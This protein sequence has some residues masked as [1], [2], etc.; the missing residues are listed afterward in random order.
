MKLYCLSGLGVD[1]RAFVHFH[2][3]GVELVHIP[4]IAPKKGERLEAYAARLF[5][6]ADIPEKYALLGVSFGGMIATEFARIQKPEFLFLVSSAASRHELPWQYR[7]G[8]ILPLH[9]IL[10]N[11]GLLSGNRLIRHLFGVRNPKD[12]SMLK[13]ILGRTDP[14][15][16]RWAMHAIVMWNGS[17]QMEAIRIHGTR[18]RM[19]PIRRNVDYPISG[20]GHFMLVNR[21]SEIERIV[22]HYLSHSHPAADADKSPLI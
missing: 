14:H 3:K 22:E 10:P 13:K 19:L 18:D 6:S 15:F 5:A 17:K 9:R 16:L 8:R 2:P 7:A 4:W 21:A 12:T 1:E 20:G 11:K